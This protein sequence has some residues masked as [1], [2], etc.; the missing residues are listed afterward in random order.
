MPAG[1]S[2]EKKYQYSEQWSGSPEA[3]KMERFATIVYEKKV[4][5]RGE[6][7]APSLNTAILKNPVFLR[8]W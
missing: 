4:I 1:S 2:L 6:V 3:S 8:R 5:G 7:L